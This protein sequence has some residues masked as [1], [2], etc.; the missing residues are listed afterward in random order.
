M[1]QGAAKKLFNN[2]TTV[3][4]QTT[5]FEADCYTVVC[6][7]QDVVDALTNQICQQTAHE[8]LGTKGIVAVHAD[9]E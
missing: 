6:H 5:N 8:N 7:K 3:E 1:A 2:A 9:M 4:K